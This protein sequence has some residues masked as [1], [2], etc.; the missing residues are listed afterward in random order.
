VKI[1]LLLPRS[2]VYPSMAFDIADG[3]KSAVKQYGITDAVFTSHNIG[4]AAKDEEIYARC[5]QVLME[6]ADVV[7]AYINPHTAEYI[8]PLFASSNKLLLVL[9]SGFHFPSPKVRL[10]HAFFI[11]L[12]GN[13]SCRIASRL[14]IQND[15]KDVAFTCSFFDAGFRSSY[16]FHNGITENGGN[17][18]YNHVTAL[19]KQEFTVQ[20][21]FENMEAKEIKGILASFCGDMAEDFFREG[22]ALGLFEKYK[23]FGSPFMA[24]ELWLDKLPYPGGDFTAVVPWARSL[25]LKENNIFLEQLNK[26]GKANVFS[27]IAWEAGMIIAGLSSSGEEMIKEIETG[28]WNSPRGLIKTDASNHQIDTPLYIATVEKNEATGNCRLKINGEVPFID[29]ERKKLQHDIDSFE[30][31][32]NCWFNAYPCLES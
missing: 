13:L 3:I 17:I 5:E 2:V 6:D 26:P 23:I 27:M 12:Q 25:D 19:H 16:A 11:S 15:C 32:A 22:A 21:L 10:T 28:T 20:P 4:V 30:G 1:G 29:E 18:L 7:V 8:H 31:S 14:A 24:E 9:D